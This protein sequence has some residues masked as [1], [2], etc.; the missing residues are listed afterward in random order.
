MTDKSATAIAKKLKTTRLSRGLTQGELAD[1]AG[2]SE[3]YYA[4]IERVEVK[5]SVEILEKLVKALRVK[6]SDILPF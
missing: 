1:K 2:I 3:N 6:S 4:R 5:P